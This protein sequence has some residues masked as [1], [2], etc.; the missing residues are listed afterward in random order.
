MIKIIRILQIQFDTA[1]TQYCS[2]LIKK[3]CDR[4]HCIH[5]LLVSSPGGVKSQ[6]TQSSQH[7]ITFKFSFIMRFREDLQVNCLLIR[8]KKLKLS[9]DGIIVDGIIMVYWPFCNCREHFTPCIRG[10]E[11]KRTEVKG[12]ITACRIILKKERAEYVGI[13]ELLRDW[14]G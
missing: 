7:F 1:W 14:E 5:F 4:I 2:N 6:W 13:V 12:M 10:I 8:C 9:Y 11:D 3:S